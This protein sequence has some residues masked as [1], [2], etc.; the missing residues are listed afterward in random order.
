[1][2]PLSQ[3]RAI[4]IS[5]GNR[6]GCCAQVADSRFA[7]WWAEIRSREIYFIFIDATFM[8]PRTCFK[9]L[10]NPPMRIFVFEGYIIFL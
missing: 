2:V 5:V 6:Q 8:D 1:M 10:D 4:Q 3:A 7:K 9:T